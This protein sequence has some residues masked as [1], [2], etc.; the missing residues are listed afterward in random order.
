MS[1]R[2]RIVH[3]S[4]RPFTQHGTN[5][6]RL[7]RYNMIMVCIR[8]HVRAYDK[9]VY[10]H[11][12]AHTNN[13]ERNSHMRTDTNSDRPSVRCSAPSLS[14]TLD[15]VRFY[16][17]YYTYTNNFVDHTTSLYVCIYVRICVYCMCVIVHVY[18]Q[19]ECVWGDG[20]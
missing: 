1:L 19:R 14:V 12:C 15:I 3:V 6:Q 13:D 8:A 17:R 5:T 4:L 2:G 20:G 16:K 18:I 10:T 9:I 7:N 11:I